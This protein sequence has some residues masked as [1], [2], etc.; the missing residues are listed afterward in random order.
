MVKSGGGMSQ[1]GSKDAEIQQHSGWLIP[2]AAG[3]VILALG[4]F[5]LL[6]DLRP[7]AGLF[8]N[9][10]PTAN[11]GA[12]RVSVRGVRF[13][14]PGNYLDARSSRRGG[15]LDVMT[16][17][18]LLPDMRGYSAGESSLFL[19]NAPDSPVVHLILRGDT[20]GLT[21][22]DRLQRIYRPY[23]ADP[24]GTAAQFGL[25]HYVFRDGT[26]YERNDLY[27]GDGG[28]GP[29]LF[30]CERPAQDLPSPNCLAIDRPVASGVTLSYRFKLAQLSGWR[31]I[32][33]G[34][35]RLI[36]SFMKG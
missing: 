31:A 16:L 32:S 15:D 21:P 23:M 14:I 2:L 12:V 9:V 29:S 4:A 10:S 5:F 36:G 8:R 11:A 13:T 7:G 34:V 25:T 6:Y 19:N 20:N 28:S 35:D 26:G 1:P 18:A 24:K 33:Q 22:A 30:L 17:S 3:L 27:A